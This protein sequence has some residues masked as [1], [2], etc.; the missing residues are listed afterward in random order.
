ML[1]VRQRLHVHPPPKRANQRHG[2]LDLADPYLDL[3]ELR[4]ECL[5]L[6]NRDAQIIVESVFVQH[7]RDGQGLRGLIAGLVLLRVLGRQAL[8]LA[9]P[10]FHF[11]EGSEHRRPIVVARLRVLRP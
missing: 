10:V 7:R 6:R 4:G 8:C 5:H 1:L 2:G 11:L 3:G 9:Q